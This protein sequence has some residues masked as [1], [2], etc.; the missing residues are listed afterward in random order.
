MDHDALTLHIEADLAD[1]LKMTADFVG[2]PVDDYA[3]DLIRDGLDEGWAEE[4][5]R[6]AE[7]ER[8]G[9][10]IPAEP[11]LLEFRNSV[12]ARFAARK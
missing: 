4:Q 2:R 10:S 1:R 9:E 3:R 5:A 8:T 12:K 7:F 6:W 11:A